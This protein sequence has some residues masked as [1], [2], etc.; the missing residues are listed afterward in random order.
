MRWKAKFSSR[1]CRTTISTSPFPL[2]IADFNDASNF[3][4]LLRS[5]S[6]E[7]Y[8]GYANPK[9]DALLD[10][11]QTTADPRARGALMQQAEDLALAD[12]AW[13]PAYFMVTRDLVNPRVKG[14]I[15]NVRDMNRT[16]W[17]WIEDKPGTH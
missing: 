3:L 1:W 2:W 10:A 6:G 8:S 13:V 11:A 7:N 17:L 5:G 15:A 4:D 9:Y 12:Y 16:R 14:W